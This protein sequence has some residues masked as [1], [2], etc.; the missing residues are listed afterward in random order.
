MDR[1][2]SPLRQQSTRMA[3]WGMYRTRVEG[4]NLPSG[5]LK[6]QARRQKN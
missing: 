2:R 3:R 5:L 1:A 4:D 6:N